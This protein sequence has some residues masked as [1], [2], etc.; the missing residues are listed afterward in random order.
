MFVF[1]E[2]RWHPIENYADTV[3]VQVVNKETKIVGRAEATCRRKITSG[4]IAPGV[5][6]RVLG[7]RHDFNVGKA[8]FFNVFHQLNSQLAIIK[9]FIGPSAPP[10]TEMNL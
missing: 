1:G 10:G 6:E 5:I 8:Q 3:L 9:K 7:D 4:L 2:V